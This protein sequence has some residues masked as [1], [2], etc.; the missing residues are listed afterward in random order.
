MVEDTGGV[1]WFRPGGFTTGYLLMPLRGRN[2][3]NS[4]MAL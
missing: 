1:R 4:F 2:A 3:I